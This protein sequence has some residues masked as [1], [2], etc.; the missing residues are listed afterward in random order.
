MLAVPHR[1]SVMNEPDS[2]GGPVKLFVTGKNDNL[3]FPSGLSRTGNL[4]FGL[5]KQSQSVCHSK[6]VFVYPLYQ[7][8]IFIVSP[9][10]LVHVRGHVLIVVLARVSSQLVC[11][12]VASP[13]VFGDLT[14][15]L[16]L[17]SLVSWDPFYVY[18][19]STPRN[20]SFLPKLPQ[21]PVWLVNP[22]RWLVAPVLDSSEAFHNRQIV[23]SG[24][25][26][27]RSDDGGGKLHARGVVDGGTQSLL[28][29]RLTTP[30]LRVLYLDVVQRVSGRVSVKVGDANPSVGGPRDPR[31]KD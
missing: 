14:L 2:S 22:S 5:R 1:G 15:V 29:V 3:G 18:G 12:G 13:V 9:D 21:I 30:R 4:L 19:F 11:D 16:I 10:C 31:Q 27:V 17:L 25:R 23:N 26:S 8:P 20:D 6:H 28:P 7:L 24:S